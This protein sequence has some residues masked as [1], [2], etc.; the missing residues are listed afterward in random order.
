MAS[1]KRLVLTLFLAM[2]VMVMARAADGDYTVDDDGN[3]T[4]SKIVEGINANKT[5]IYSSARKYITNAY[6]V[7]KYRIVQEDADMGTII[8]KGTFLN[9]CTLNIFPNTFY[10]TSDFYLR[11]DAK[12]GRA[13]ISVY[14]DEYGGQ[15]QNIN[16]TE[17][18]HVHIADAPPIGSKVE[19]NSRLYTKAFPL[20]IEQMQSVLGEVE[21]TLSKA[22][23]VT[24]DDW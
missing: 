5:D 1:G 23:S 11:I 19:E 14:A 9:Y 7:T 16:V 17:E 22:V 4:I 20:L 2:T 8:G 24:Q 10:I 18:M 15:R 21:E 3:V 12:E 13:R 6:K